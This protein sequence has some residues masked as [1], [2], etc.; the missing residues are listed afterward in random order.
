MFLPGARYFIVL[1]FGVY[2]TDVVCA[3]FMKKI[4]YSMFPNDATLFFDDATFVTKTI[5]T[6]PFLVKIFES[7]N[8]ALFYDRFYP[9]VAHYREE[10]IYEMQAAKKNEFKRMQYYFLF[11][12]RVKN[13]PVSRAILS[14]LV[15]GTVLNIC[16]AKL[17][18]Q[19][20]KYFSQDQLSI[21]WGQIS[22]LDW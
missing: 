13:V 12:C 10:K 16:P 2:N 22:R 11:V 8:A 20:K 18:N 7:R 15:C 5:V 9:V 1:K 17:A 19:E 3:V 4:T 21:D 6:K 14:F